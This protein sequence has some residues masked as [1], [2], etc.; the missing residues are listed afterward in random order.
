M[1][2]KTLYSLL[3]CKE[4]KPVHPKGNQPWIIIGRTDAEAEAP[5]RWPAIAKSQLIGKDPDAGKDWRQEKKGQQ[6]MRWL[7]GITDSMDM[8]L[9]KFWKIVKDRQAW[10]GAAHGLAKSQTRLRGWTTAWTAKLI[11]SQRD[12]YVLP[13]SMPVCVQSFSHVWF[14]VN[15]WTLACQAP[16]SMEIPRQ[17]YLS[18]VPFPPPRDLPHPGI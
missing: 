1:L 12:K 7:D 2:E 3:D 8:S 13:C 16:L 4:I 18:G 15:T 10:H 11:G 17:E 9:S 5:I 14:F 6:R